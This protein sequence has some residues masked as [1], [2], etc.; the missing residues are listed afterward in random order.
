MLSNE[1]I[2]AIY[3]LREAVETKV[4]AEHALELVP[5]PEARV[6]LLEATLD[7]ESKTQTAI[8]VCHECG[9]AH[10]LDDEHG[11]NVIEVNFRREGS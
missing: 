4:R 3:E 8:D 10:G 7:V 1:K 11:G 2:D 5:S 9:R 6:A